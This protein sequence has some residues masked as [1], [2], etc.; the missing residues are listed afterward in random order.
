MFYRFQ[1][2]TNSGVGQQCTAIVQAEYRPVAR[3]VDLA[4]TLLSYL[5]VAYDPGDMDGEDLGIATLPAPPP[6]P[7]PV[8]LAPD[9]GDDAPR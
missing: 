9:D 7:L 1:G 2:Y 6:S 5:G 4:P 8:I 3:T